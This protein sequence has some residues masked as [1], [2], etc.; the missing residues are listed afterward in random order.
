MSPDKAVRCRCNDHFWFAAAKE[1]SEKWSKTKT[2][3]GKMKPEKHSS[4][5]MKGSVLL[6]KSTVPRELMFLDGPYSMYVYV[7]SFC[8]Y[9]RNDSAK[10]AIVVRLL[11]AVGGVCQTSSLDSVAA[12]Q[13]VHVLH[14]LRCPEKPVVL[15]FN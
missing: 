14:A 7:H 11:P 2:R 1:V 5:A 3:R 10:D 8:T 13:V 4:T 6:K 12:W 9:L 15:V